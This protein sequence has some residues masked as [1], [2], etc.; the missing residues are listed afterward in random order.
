MNLRLRIEPSL[1]ERLN[2]ILT[3][4]EHELHA[5]T[6]FPDPLAQISTHH[7]MDAGGKR[8]R[9]LLALLAAQF[10]PE[11]ATDQVLDAAVVVELIH[12]ATLY[13]DDVMD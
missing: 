7:L 11:G 1:E 4:V 9:P 8:L 10:G 2:Q 6:Q 5:A 12:L 13:H 3:R